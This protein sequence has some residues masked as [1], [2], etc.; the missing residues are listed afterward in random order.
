MKPNRWR[1]HLRLALLLLLLLIATSLIAAFTAPH[2][3]A[4]ATVMACGWPVPRSHEPDE[5]LIDR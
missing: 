4:T 5:A 3:V 2:L 1:W